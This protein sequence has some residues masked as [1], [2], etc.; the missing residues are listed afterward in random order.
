MYKGTVMDLLAWMATGNLC[1]RGFSMLLFMSRA[2]KVLSCDDF[3]QEMSFKLKH[4]GNS[5][6]LD[7][8]PDEFYLAS[9]GFRE[10]LERYGYASTMMSSSNATLDLLYL[11]LD[12]NHLG[13]NSELGSIWFGKAADCF[14]TNRFLARRVLGLF[15]EYIREGALCPNHIFTYKP[16]LCDRLPAWCRE[17]LDSFLEQKRRVHMADSTVCMYRSAVTRFCMFLDKEGMT[18]FK[19]ITADDLKKFN[20]TDPHATVEGKNA[21]NVRIRSFLLFLAEEGYIENYFIREALPCAAAPKARI[22]RI[23]S[24]QEAQTLEKYDMEDTALKLRDNAIIQIGLRMGLR[25]SDITSLELSHIDWSSRSIC[26]CQDKTEVGKILPMPTAV[27]NALYRYLTEGRPASRS[28]YIFITHKAPYKKVSRS[29]C[30]GIMQ[31]AFPSKDEGRPG[32]HATRRTYATDRFRNKCG[33]SQV[34][35]LLGHTTTG[36]VH[37]YLSLDEENMRLCPIPLEDAGIPMEGGFRDE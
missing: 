10:E 32:F 3:P 28:R 36:T 5:R 13:Y 26:F 4:I 15:D 27:G 25:G 37:K 29:V 8:P 6:Y 30:Q 12:M 14:G 16:L 35:D 22:V 9:L 23:L 7:F 33:Y 20:V 34:A 1:P 2:E 11:F 31:R 21:Y 19:Q 24:E 18:S 17:A